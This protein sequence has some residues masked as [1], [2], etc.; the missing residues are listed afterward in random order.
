MILLSFLEEG[1]P[2]FGLPSFGFKAIFLMWTAIRLSV[3]CI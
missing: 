1:S 3:A 2:A